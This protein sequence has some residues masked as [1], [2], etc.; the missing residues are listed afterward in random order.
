[1]SALLLV[2]ALAAAQEEDCAEPMSQSAMNRCAAIDFQ[3]AD[4]ELN[5]VWPEVLAEMRRRDRYIPDGDERPSSVQ[6]LREAQR[7][8]IVL[9]DAHCAVQGYE[10]R[11]GTMEPLL[12]NGCR[13]AT[14]RARTEQLRSLMVDR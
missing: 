4:A 14:T 9:R 3:E 2:L 10:A 7:A 5:R 6:S 12:Y 13:A 8:W 11:G 1:M